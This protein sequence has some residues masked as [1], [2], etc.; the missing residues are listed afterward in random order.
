MK[1]VVLGTAG[2]IDHGKT[3]L[4]K[5]LTGIDT[6][7]LL[8]E[9]RRGISIELG[10][11]RME[12]GDIRFGIVDVPGHE[13]FIKNMLAGAGG[14]DMV[15]LVIAA[16]EG[17]MPQTREHLDII[18]FLE[19]ERGVVAL[20]KSDLVDEEAIEIARL[21]AEEAIASTTIKG[22]SIIPVSATTG[23][24]LDELKRALV[25]VAA[26]VHTR[27]ESGAFRLPIDRVFV[28]EGFGTVVTGT[29]FSGSV[30][31]GDRLD[32]L[33]SGKQVRVRR[34]QVHGKDAERAYA[35]QRTALA[36]HGV[37][38]DEVQRGEHVVSPESL[39]NSYMVDVRLR[40]SPRW[41][42]P[43]R[44]RER[45][46]F[47]LASSE[48]LGRIALLEG[49]SVEPGKSALAQIRLETPV[50]PAVGDRFV[51]RSYSPMHTMAG[52]TVIDPHPRKHGRQ[53][54][55]E[56]EALRS[57]EEGGHMAL[58]LESVANAGLKGVKTQDLVE[59]TSMTRDEVEQAV[60]AEMEIGTIRRSENG[61]I[62][63][64]DVWGI[65]RRTILEQGRRF[66]ERHPMRWGMT[67]E[68]FRA[69]LGKD[70]STPVV[71]ELD[72]R[73][74]K[75]RIGG[76]DIKFEGKAAGERDRIDAAF[77][78][79]G[80][81]PPDV[82]EVVAASRDRAIATEVVAALLDQEV[83]IKVT[84]DI[85]LHREAWAALLAA[86][87][88]IAARDK[89]ISVQA[90][91]EE[92]GISRKYSVPILEYLDARKVTRR[93]GDVRVLLET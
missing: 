39:A 25:D 56:I 11:A 58:F 54:I 40:V 73:G 24:G 69:A 10:F 33:P 76:G 5:A 43:I 4:V 15:L 85:L 83:L 47:H 77:R 29:C 6:D 17:V 62:F 72:L 75:V 32:I 49:E 2:H 84:P 22:A 37:S 45:I 66:Q 71:G 38:K 87:R 90:I 20:T 9:K 3:S 34:I 80:C 89:T 41:V 78:T 68:E 88:K 7:R 59:A 52:G 93:E 28:M 31:I 50:V 82:K 13:R 92:L 63:S 67:R 23:A 64:T 26:S 36:L 91:R 8:E 1:S 21:D 48:D 16:D 53:R 55:D 81:A 60:A 74:D 35:G 18:D 42:R 86:L 79:A 65:A 19:V 61:R 14:I 70:A 51:V 12:I 27:S 30:G 57:R 44:H 46:R